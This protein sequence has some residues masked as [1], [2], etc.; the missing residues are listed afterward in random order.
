MIELGVCGFIRRGEMCCIYRIYLVTRFLIIVY[1]LKLD[2]Y[3]FFFEKRCLN[4]LDYYVIFVYSRLVFLVFFV[5]TIGCF[6][7]VFGGFVC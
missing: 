4:L 7:F 5:D 2:F 6:I 1:F 3:G